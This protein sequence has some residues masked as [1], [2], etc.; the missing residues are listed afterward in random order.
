LSW[1]TVTATPVV[2]TTKMAL[3]ELLL[4]ENEYF[5]ELVKCG[6]VAGLQEWVDQLQAQNSY[7]TFVNRLSILLRDFDFKGLKQLAQF[8]QQ[9]NEESLAN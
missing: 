8:Y 2:T 9:D 5:Q 3:E 4:S 7:P 1:N 6:D